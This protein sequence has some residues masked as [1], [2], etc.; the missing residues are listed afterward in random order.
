MTSLKNVR[1]VLAHAG[2]IFDA[3]SAPEAAIELVLATR[4]LADHVWRVVREW[5]PVLDQYASTNLFLVRDDGGQVPL[6]GDDAAPLPAERLFVV[7]SDNPG[8]NALPTEFNAAVHE[9][10]LDQV[11]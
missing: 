2:T 8:S 9:R 5:D 6:D 3:V 4:E 1:D 11:R 7:T 10:F